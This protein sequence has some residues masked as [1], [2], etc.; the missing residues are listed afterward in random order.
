V[1][2]PTCSSTCCNAWANSDKPT[3]QDPNIEAACKPEKTDA[4]YCA[5]KSKV[6]QCSSSVVAGVW[7]KD[8]AQPPPGKIVNF[9]CAG[10][11]T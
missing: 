10:G 1:L 11:G 5:V 4:C 7:R 9:R 2:F 6:G 8:G 3:A